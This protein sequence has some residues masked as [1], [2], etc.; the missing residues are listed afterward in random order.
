[1]PAPPPP[2]LQVLCLPLL[3]PHDALPWGKDDEGEGRGA[4]MP[5]ITLLHSRATPHCLHMRH[6]PHNSVTPQAVGRAPTRGMR[7]SA[8]LSPLDSRSSQGQSLS[9]GSVPP[10]SSQKGQKPEGDRESQGEDPGGQAGR[11][12]GGPSTPHSLLTLPSM[13]THLP[14]GRGPWTGRLAETG[15]GGAPP[16]PLPEETTGCPKTLQEQCVP[17]YL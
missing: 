5:E 11:E 3:C 16:E 1:M 17:A 10:L 6:L 9:P 8:P 2:Q 15:G 14:S 4:G 7:P 12:H 13:H